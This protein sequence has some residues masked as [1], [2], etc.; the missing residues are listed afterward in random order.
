MVYC[1]PFWTLFE[2]MGKVVSGRGKEWRGTPLVDATIDF[3]R[4]FA[5]DDSKGKT[6]AKEGGNGKSGKGKERYDGNG[7]LVKE[8]DDVEENVTDSFL[9]TYVY[10]ALKEKKRF[11]NMRVCFFVITQ[12]LFPVLTYMIQGGHQEDA[13]EFL[14]F[15]LDT[16]EEELL[17]ILSS[18]SPSNS[19]M[20]MKGVSPVE[21]K[22]EAAPPADDGWLE[23]GKRNRTVLT[24][25]V[26]GLG[27]S[28]L[29]Y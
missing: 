11:D 28:R 21:E 25:T 27:R 16:L 14:G 20:K 6:K 5:V 17:S 26:S 7:V 19:K 1:E 13:E 9:P 23:V 2:E 8:E 12:F 10:E 15:Y 24:R 4:E 29:R 3:L 18:L 22:E